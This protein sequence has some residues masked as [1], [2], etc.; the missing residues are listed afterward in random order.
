[1]TEKRHIAGLTIAVSLFLLAMVCRPILIFIIPGVLILFLPTFK[2][3]DLITLITYILGISLAFWICS[4]W[5]LQFIPLSSTTFLLSVTAITALIILYCLF[6]SV[7]PYKI[8]L[9]SYN[10]ILIFLFL[11][12][13]GL[14]LLPMQHSITA[15]G[16]DMSCHTYMTNLMVN[17]NG[18]PDNYHPIF[19]L[20]EFNTYP[21]GFHTISALI[22][23]TSGMP[24]FRSTFV[25]ACLTYVFITLFLFVFLRKF[26]S[27]EFAF[28]SAINFSFFTRNPQ[29]FASWGGN[30]TIFALALFILFISFLDRIKGNT[31]W[32][33]L[34]SAL[35][36]ASVLLTHTIIFVQSFYI[37]GVS[38]LVYFLLKK[39]Y[40]GLIWLKY[41]LVVTLFLII[42]APYLI[43]VNYGTATPRTLDW[44]KNWVRNPSHDWIWHGTISDFIWTIPL[45]IKG[46]IFGAGIFKYSLF[47]C[48]IGFILLWI[49]NPKRGIQYTTFLILGVLLI[50]NTKYWILPFSYAIYPERVATM[51][52]IPLSLFF[53]YALEVPFKYFENRKLFNKKFL[54]IAIFGL[55]IFTMTKVPKFNKMNYAGGILSQ[56]AVT[57]ADLKAFDWLEKHTSRA[58]VIQNNYGDAGLWIPSIIFRPITNAH[59][60]VIYLDKTK[61]LEGPGYVYIGKKCVY[62]CPLKNADFKDNN[63]YKLVYS[64]DGVYIYKIR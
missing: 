11:L 63:R 16:A 4:F 59:I 13:L 43:T 23:L 19:R 15:A 25:M 50:L 17:A 36:L 6:K 2:K 30:P 26:V 37:F 45:Y 10:F 44:I 5:Y 52:I 40:K 47:I 55:I 12:V 14:R 18:V 32:L 24:P 28:V 62:G 54:S 57:K 35:S 21:V 33:I 58:D 49:K 20:D 38:F 7:K 1:M 22:S 48:P 34:F 8:S 29:N 61:P 46:Y 39:E 56:S 51:T 42:A 60:N 27:W 41:L 31:K 3:I 53:A 64:R 9:D